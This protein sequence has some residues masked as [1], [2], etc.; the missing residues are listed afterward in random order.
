MIRMMKKSRRRCRRCSL[1]AVLVYATTKPDT[2]HVERSDEHSGAARYD[3]SPHR[4]F[5]V[6]DRVV[7]V[8]E[9]RSGA[10]SGRSAARRAG[11][12]AVYEWNGNSEVG[13]G[14]MEI[15]DSNAVEDR[16][17]AR[18]HQAVRRSQHRRI[19]FNPRGGTPTTRQMVDA[20][21]RAIT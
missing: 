11:K 9:T 18:F 8:G 19:P 20:T 17:Q 16:D 21:G 14:R 3:S 15:L 12:G 2:L 1:L 13:Q 5:H 4:R 7:A 10:A 6:V